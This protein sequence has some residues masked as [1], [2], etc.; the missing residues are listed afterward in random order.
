MAASLGPAGSKEI[1]GLLTTSVS[2]ALG[3]AFV[4]LG[5]LNVWLVLEGW[6]RVKAAKANSLMLAAHRIG[7]YLFIGLFCIMAYSMIARLRNGTGDASPTTTVHLALAMVLSPLL[8]IKVLIA[9]YYKNQHGL[10]LPIGL[11]IFVLAFVLI[12]STAGPYLA[13]ASRIEQVSIDPAHLQPVTI[14]LNEAADLTQKRCSKCHNLDRVVGARKDAQG[15][16][17]TVNRMRAM[18]AAGISDSEALAIVSY[19]ASQDRPEGSGIAARM[20]VERALVD[21]RCARCHNLDRVYKTVQP[22][23]EWRQTVARMGGYAAGSTGAFQPGEDQQIIDY[24]SATQ[25]PEAINQRRTQVAS[26]SG[27]GLVAQKPAAPPL[28]PERSSPY[29]GKTIGFI[30]FVCLALAMLIIKR[31]RSR[32]RP[33]APTKLATQSQTASFAASRPANTPFILQLVRITQQ[34]PDTKTLRFVVRGSRRLEALPG[35]FLAFS[36]LLDGRKE[37]RCYSICS[38][39]ARPGYVE[40]TPKR[41]NDGCVS[42]FLNDRASIGL[43]VEA[44]GPFGQFCLD[45]ASDKRIV[46]LAAGSGITPMMAMLR[47]IDDLCLDTQAT[48][49]YCVRTFQDIIFRDELND[50]QS[51][52]R[53]FQCH[54]LLSQADDSWQGARGRINREFICKAVPDLKG[55]VFFLCGPPPFMEA[56]RAILSE[57]G[58]EREAIRQETFGGSGAE[59]RALPPSTERRF[60]VEFARS[61]KTSAVPEGQTLLEAAAAAG[62]EIPSACRQGQCGTCRTRLLDGQVRMTAEQG[63][64]SESKAQGFVLTCVGHPDGNVRLDA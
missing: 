47:Y 59:T 35:Q 21:Q 50:L 25:T 53:N 45:L 29:N 60:M 62:V 18:P 24:L 15:W 39:P 40:I 33:P 41:V 28:T 63:L 23:D 48:L 44:S 27:S 54:L 37:T 32:T 22:P 9:R 49:L 13:R 7:G 46:L 17:A 36:F 1:V 52:L 6:S 19:L 8:F 20:A 38:S 61:R 2:V 55:R 26:P 11:T 58:V 5:G 42:V 14:D 3:V 30:S 57:L 4:F 43:T 12:A 64:D 51:R 10:L 31:P 56:A 16:L 34:T